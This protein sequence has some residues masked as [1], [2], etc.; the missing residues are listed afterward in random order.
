MNMFTVLFFFFFFF[1]FF[2]LLFNMSRGYWKSFTDGIQRILL[3]TP[4]EEVIY[5]VRSANTFTLPLLE[6]SVSL[7]A[8]GL[9]LVD[10]HRK[11]ELAYISVLP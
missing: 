8:V 9:S 4:D 11:Q 3:F 5:R 10:N 7:K 6:A 2:S 1:S